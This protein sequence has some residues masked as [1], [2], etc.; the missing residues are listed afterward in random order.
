MNILANNEEGIKFAMGK[1]NNEIRS[2]SEFVG[3]SENSRLQINDI[4]DFM[5]VCNFFENM[6]AFNVQND[7]EL[8]DDLKMPLLQLLHLQILLI[9]I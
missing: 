9:I 4:Q 2:L 3:E 8:I 1:T 6:K 7:F 5:N